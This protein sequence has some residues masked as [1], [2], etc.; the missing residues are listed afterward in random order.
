M[1]QTFQQVNLREA[2]TQ[3]GKEPG[4]ISLETKS[5]TIVL[6]QTIVRLFYDHEIFVHSSGFSGP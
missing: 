4:K 5:L 1:N 6:F 2:I 3:L